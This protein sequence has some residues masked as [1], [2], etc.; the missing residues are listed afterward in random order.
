MLWLLCCHY[1]LVSQPKN[2]IPGLCIMRTG[3]TKH[4]ERSQTDQQLPFSFK[5]PCCKCALFPIRVC[6]D[7]FLPLSRGSTSRLFVRRLI[8][9]GECPKTDRR[10]RWTNTGLLLF[11]QLRTQ[12]FL[13]WRLSR[14]SPM[15]SAT[16]LLLLWNS[17]FSSQIPPKIDHTARLSWL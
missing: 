17:T 4:T 6:G 16:L 10:P 15:S 14:L 11:T 12:T 13:I 7:V 2:K 8:N 1:L 9:V 5:R 3:I